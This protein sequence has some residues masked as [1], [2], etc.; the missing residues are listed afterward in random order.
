MSGLRLDELR[1][2]PWGCFEDLKL[3]FGPVG[4]VDLVLGPNAAGKST[5]TRGIAALLFGIGQRTPDAHTY[6]YQDLRIGAKVAC[7]EGTVDLVRRKGR[8]GTLT[9]ADG[10]PLPDDFMIAV[11]G[12]IGREVFESLL[13]IDNDALKNGG[14]EL[15]QG[16]GEVGASLFAAAAG[17]ASLHDVIAGLEESA[18][19]LFSPRARN[20]R[21]HAAIRDL[22]DA[23]KRLRDATF[24]PQRHKDMEREV[25]H[26]LKESKAISEEIRTL[27]VERGR[28]DRRRKVA[29][30]VGHHGEI[31]E[32]LAE[33]QGTPE[34]AASA[35]D[36]RIA[37]ETGLARAEEALAAAEKKRDELAEEIEQHESDQRF[38]GVAV[39]IEALVAGHSA[40]LKGEG[41]KPRL[42]REALAAEEKV[43]AAAQ[44]AGVTIEEI[45][46]LR[47]PPAV[48]G[49]LDDAVSAHGML[50]ERRRA[51][52]EARE[53]A[54]EASRDAEAA[55]EATAEAPDLTRLS[56]ALGAAVKLGPIEDRVAE[57]G[58]ERDRL[59]EAAGLAFER[60]A[61]RPSS[62]D[63]MAKMTVPARDEIR[64]WLTGDEELRREARDLEAAED[65]LRR[66]GEDLDRR[67]E[68][69]GGDEG[70]PGPDELIAARAAREDSWRALRGDV[71]AG[72]S[73]AAGRMDDH[74]VKVAE[75][76]SIADRQL[77]GSTEL[78]RMSQIERERRSLD[79]ER[80]ANSDAAGRLQVS[81]EAKAEQ[82]PVLWT[83]AGIEAPRPEGALE[84][85]ADREK[86]LELIA[87]REEAGADLKATSGCLAEH[88]DALEGAL[89]VAGEEV[90]GCSFGELLEIAEA[91]VAEAA[92]A[93]RARE[94]A[95]KA[96]TDAARRL[97]RAEE[98]AGR[99]DADLAGWTEGWPEILDAVG[100]PPRTTPEVAMRISR[101]IAEGLDQRQK[102]QELERR[103][104][105]IERDTSEYAEK[106][107][108][109]VAELAPDLADRE[110]GRAASL[111]GE[112]LQESRSLE[113][114]RTALVRRL[115]EVEEEVEA[116]VKAIL[117]AKEAIA[118]VLT[119]AGCEDLAALPEIEEKSAEA[120]R[121]RDEMADLERRVVELG[122]GRFDELSAA[123]R[124]LDI[125]D[126]DARLKEIDETVEEM[127]DAR[128]TLNQELGAKEGELRSAEA[129]TAAVEARE[130]IEFIKEEI[131]NLVKDYASARLGSV[132]VVRAME[133]Y[134]REHENPLLDR[135]NEL[136]ARITLGDFVELFVDQDDQ[137]GPVLLGRQRDRKVKRVEQM[138][139]G[140]REQ[141]FL[142]LRIAVI[143]RFVETTV[144]A[145][146]IFD[147]AFLESDD[148]RSEKIFESLAELASKTQV[149]VLT[150][151]PG[152]AA[153]GEKV[154]GAG[155]TIARLPA[156]SPPV[157]SIAA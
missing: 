136:F 32:R 55:L 67:E 96:A 46:G 54:E 53:Q 6:E 147:D 49:R 14:A 95:Q 146:V 39:E 80:R 60:L 18:K 149:I 66:R 144:P 106:V 132:V 65:A 98:V 72:T 31:A 94:D 109:L 117:A 28:L 157:L 42:E 119:A 26:M 41:D 79:D 151:R 121:L 68:E 142:S 76:D 22:K 4:G 86:L 57:A 17:I 138:S 93:G 116:S 103:I 40:V 64:A 125:A 7:A 30:L 88:R 122:E 43:A 104:A 139:R 87:S 73:P 97:A 61:P 135:A 114:A 37:A 82:W 69:I 5:M 130:E 123:V 23:E 33:L 9:R 83:A 156:H 13:L 107:G 90:D 101:A 145:P 59:E 24:R 124:E 137:I 8:S 47:R 77:A 52:A 91:K 153:L 29:P 21:I 141:L 70:L 56:A 111:L 84:W 150:H 127:T 115:P 129:D 102:Q 25:S 1:L 58:A 3:P 100:L 51:A 131:R 105:G 112:R 128:E 36:D 108:L 38:S 19:E 99:A 15:L 140:T 50:T 134:R 2:E 11:A 148:D 152:Q 126:V 16:K 155:I 133:R 44:E 45:E 143:E 71:E 63:A 20:D 85:L 48:R 10:G 154:L 78:E 12:G 75:A 81:R 34:L 62:L 27:G 74:E 118:V 35:R 113:A 110:P 92:S 120:G 89:R